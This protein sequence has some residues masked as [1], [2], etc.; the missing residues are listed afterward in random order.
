MI[1][2]VQTGRQRIVISDST[3]TE[4]KTNRTDVFINTKYKITLSIVL[5]QHWEE[6]LNGTGQMH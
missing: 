1:V 3:C 5:W 6:M 4:K 2:P